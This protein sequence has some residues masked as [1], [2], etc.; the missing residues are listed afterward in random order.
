MSKNSYENSEKQN[1]DVGL[2]HIICTKKR[3]KWKYCSSHTRIGGWNKE[4][5]GKYGIIHIK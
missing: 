1:W 5:N 3:K 2:L 4:Q